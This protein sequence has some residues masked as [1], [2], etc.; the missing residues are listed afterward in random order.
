MHV[1]VF[2]P[3]YIG[4]VAVFGLPHARGGVSAGKREWR[5]WAPSSPCTWGCFPDGRWI[6]GK[7]GVFPMHVGVF[8]IADGLAWIL[9]G[10]PHARGGVSKY[11]AKKASWWGSSPCTW[12]CFRYIRYALGCVRVFPMHVGV[13]LSQTSHER[14]PA[15][16]PHARGGVS[17]KAKE[18][19]KKKTSSPCTWGCFS[20]RRIL[21]R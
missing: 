6:C 1:G 4:Y 11:E 16:L 7:G 12:G 18:R 15:G 8:P 19:I 10:L 20:K 21:R 5:R 14:S 2:L 3:A 13:F 9:P 17:Q